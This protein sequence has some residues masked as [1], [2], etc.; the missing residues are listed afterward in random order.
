[1]H[2]TSRRFL[3]SIILSRMLVPRLWQYNTEGR[4][5]FSPGHEIRVK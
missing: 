1:M 2:V 4:P 5:M 3:V